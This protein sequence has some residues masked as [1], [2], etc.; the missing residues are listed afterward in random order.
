MSSALNDVPTLS[1]QKTAFLKICLAAATL[2][3]DDT[4]LP[5]MS[6]AR[7]RRT[8]FCT[9]VGYRL[10]AAVAVSVAMITDAYV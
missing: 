3:P 5:T 4:D 2:T 10:S 7:D 8:V 6:G 9:V 1:T